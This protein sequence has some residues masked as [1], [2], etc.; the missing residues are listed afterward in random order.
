MTRFGMTALALAATATLS[1]CAST[2]YDRYADQ[3][4]RER[5]EQR[6][7]ATAAG[8][9]IGAAAGAAVDSN[10]ARG[11]AIGGA[12]GALIGNQIG[13]RTSEVCRGYFQQY[14]EPR[15]GYGY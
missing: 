12:A 11:A 4:E 8:G 13:N 6:A 9:L 10:D 14:P 15:R 3:C 2:R 1:G 5:A 7:L